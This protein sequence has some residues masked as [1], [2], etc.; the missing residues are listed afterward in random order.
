MANYEFTVSSIFRAD[1]L[2][3][4]GRRVIMPADDLRQVL[5]TST[6]ANRINIV[7]DDLDLQETTLEAIRIVIGKG[8]RTE[9]LRDLNTALFG[10]LDQERLAM[11]VVISIVTVIAL[12]N[13]MSSMVMLGRYKAREIAILR[14]M[15]MSKVSVAKVFV[16]VGAA[17]GLAG[18][19]AGLGIGLA[20]K[21]AKDPVAALVREQVAGP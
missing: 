14:T 18:E 5:G 21:A 4:D 9:T 1:V 15:G 12:S 16:G 17:M 20:L 7:L 13:I 11:T 3:V 8:Y 2:A 6:V 19:V 10:A